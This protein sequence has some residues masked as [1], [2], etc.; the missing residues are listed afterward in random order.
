MI[1]YDPTPAVEGENELAVACENRSIRVAL[2]VLL[3]KVTCSKTGENY[4][5]SQTSKYLDKDVV[6]NIEKCSVISAFWTTGSAVES[7]SAAE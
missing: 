7:E 5:Q 1:A 6:A 4:F 3:E 2:G